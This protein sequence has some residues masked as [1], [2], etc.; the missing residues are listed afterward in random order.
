[1]KALLSGVFGRCTYVRY[2]WVMWV[3][4]VPLES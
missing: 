3:R 4:G 2:D 1:M